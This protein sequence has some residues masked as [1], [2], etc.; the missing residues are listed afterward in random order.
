[1]VAMR[2]VLHYNKP[3][4]I[5]GDLVAARQT[6]E[7]E[8]AAGRLIERVNSLMVGVI[9]SE[10]EK[11]GREKVME[12]NSENSEV[13]FRPSTLNEFKKNV[14]DGLRDSRLVGELSGDEGYLFIMNEGKRVRPLLMAIGGLF[15]K[16]FTSESVETAISIELIH[17]ASVILDDFIDRDSIREGKP[18]F[19]VEFGEEK[20]FEYFERLIGLSR[21]IFDRVLL[22]INKRGETL[23]AR[24]LETLYSE[25]IN[26]MANGCLMDL[27]EK[28][29]TE[30]ETVIIS[31]LQSSIL[32]RNSLLLGLVLSSTDVDEKA[33]TTVSTIGL[34][35]G[36]I[37][38]SFND[39]EIF[40]N[41]EKQMQTKGNVYT[42]L[43]KGRKNIV[44]SK[45]PTAL[46][47]KMSVE[48]QL[49]YIE[50]HKLVDVALNE[51]GTYVYKFKDEVRT[52]PC[53][54][55][56]VTLIYFF[57]KYFREVSQS[58]KYS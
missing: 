35:L 45:I 25:I 50:R 23:K 10:K 12:R 9:K 41:P 5:I 31:D 20:T 40:I 7:E 28:P 47:E 26:E 57:R 2:E 33:Y 19:Y 52:M 16:K 18:A 34:Y 38:Q 43:V 29:K 51:I 21:D 32:L 3:I 6:P 53:S 30:K 8:R 39:V 54:I 11:V 48:E 56:K 4:S 55:G 1:M 58:I 22:R 36:K 17:K 37:F 15:N 24:K 44:S 42:D 49:A 14:D 27:D 46:R 13:L